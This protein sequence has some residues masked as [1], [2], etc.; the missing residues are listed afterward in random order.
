MEG[1]FSQDQERLIHKQ[2]IMLQSNTFCE[3]CVDVDHGSTEEDCF[4]EQRVGRIY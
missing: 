3:R 4:L 2:L 1:G